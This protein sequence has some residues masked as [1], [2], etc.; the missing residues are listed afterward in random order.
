M[1]IPWTTPAAPEVP[2]GQDIVILGSRFEL[3]SAWR[4]PAFLGHA[5][6]IWLQARRSPGIIGVSLRAQPLRA[7]FWTLSAWSSQAALR[8]SRVPTR[9]APSWPGSA[10][11]RR[12]RFSGRGANRAKRHSTR[13]PCGSRRR[14]GSPT[15]ATDPQGC[16]P[17]LRVGSLKCAAGGS[18][19]HSFTALMTR[20]ARA[21]VRFSRCPS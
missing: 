1:E 3:T 17:V 16:E 8:D 6:R 9:T 15:G 5:L 4:S 21:T 2:A 18:I 14:P 10:R 12:R 11:G 13:R 20:R 7:T 19:S